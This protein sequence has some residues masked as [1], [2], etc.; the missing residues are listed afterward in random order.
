MTIIEHTC[1]EATLS[2]PARFYA[3]DTITLGWEDR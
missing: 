3:R 2:E 1:S